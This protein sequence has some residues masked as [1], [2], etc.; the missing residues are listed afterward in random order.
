MGLTV[1]QDMNSSRGM[2][3][4]SPPEGKTFCGL[5]PASFEKGLQVALH[6]LKHIPTTETDPLCEMGIVLGNIQ[7]EIET[8]KY[9][10]PPPAGDIVIP[11]R[12]STMEWLSSFPNTRR[13][14]AIEHNGE[15]I[16][17]VDDIDKSLALLGTEGLSLQEMDPT[18][19]PAF[20]TSR[21]DSDTTNWNSPPPSAS[22][23]R[24]PTLHR[25]TPS[26]NSHLK[27][28]EKVVR[29]QRSFQSSPIKGRAVSVPNIRG[30]SKRTREMQYGSGVTTRHEVKDG[31]LTVRVSRRHVIEESTEFD[32]T[33]ALG[34]D[35][36]KMDLDASDESVDVT[37]FEIEGEDMDVVD[38]VGC[39]LGNDQP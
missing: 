1:H 25:S 4:L 23:P 13:G 24:S 14:L 35:A 28:P 32:V 3:R 30:V 15:R 22:L 2:S 34:F 6:R 26:P 33:E 31:R 18:E 19:S 7:S 37:A 17:L 11:G 29:R 8:Q 36:S 27:T 12:P 16:L 21:L 39:R 38:I 5:C 10:R 20:M 9:S